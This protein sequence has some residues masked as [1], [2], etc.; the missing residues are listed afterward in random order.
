[1]AVMAALAGWIIRRLIRISMKAI[2]LFFMMTMWD[3]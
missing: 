3:S 1:M 2:I